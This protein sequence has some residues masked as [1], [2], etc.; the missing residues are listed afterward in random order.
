MI[1]LDN[2]ASTPALPCAIEA[3]QPFL[4]EC[5]GNPSS[6]HTEG[7]RAALA[8]IESRERCA[9][10][11]GASPEEI[12]F[13][14]GG[15]ESDNTA[16]KS[17]ALSG[18]KA[19]RRRIVTT[20][21]EHPAVL[22]SCEF[23]RQLGFE[24]KLLGVDSGGFVSA[25]Q[26]RA[27]ITP[28]TALVSVMA[29]NNEVGSLQPIAE[30]AELCRKQ[31][32]TFHTDAVQAAGNIPINVRE[33]GCDMISISAHKVGGIK[34]AGLLYCRK[35]CEVTPLLHGGGQESGIRSGTENVAAI[36]A[37]GAAME[38]SC[39]DII[40]RSARIA[41]LRDRLIQLLL[42]IPGSRLNGG[43]ERRLCGNVSVS[44]S[45]VEGESMVLGLD[46]RGVCASSGSACASGDVQP[47]HVLRAMGVPE[48]FQRG[49]LRLTLSEFNRM[50]EIEQAAAAVRE[51]VEMLRKLVN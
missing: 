12:I 13:T 4:S 37:F 48:E 31:G 25:E 50:D 35:G 20:A 7:R 47:S 8:V 33:I 34:G 3:A 9:A 21:I 40:A 23:L 16:I 44:F 38:H 6:I 19:G 5:C 46:L 29:A 32:V 10:A 1:Y 14:S 11:I 17:A 22:R 30:I 26:A 45:G 41:K 39:Q 51:T 42:D 24:V 15:T 2:A 43:M 28:D 36:A 18:W 27:L 49:S